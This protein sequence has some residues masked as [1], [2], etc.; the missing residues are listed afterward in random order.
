M[1]INPTALTASLTVLFI[2]AWVGFSTRPLHKAVSRG[3]RI[4]GDCIASPALAPIIIALAAWIAQT[5]LDTQTEPYSSAVSEYFMEF[6]IAMTF[7]AYAYYGIDIL[8]HKGKEIGPT[9]KGLKIVRPETPPRYES[10]PGARIIPFPS[11][12]QG[13]AS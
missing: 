7:M 11:Q 8:L 5:Y 6:V 2:F 12:P 9:W 10:V 3:L 1:N 4:D 13:K